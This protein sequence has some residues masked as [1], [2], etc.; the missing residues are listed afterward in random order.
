MTQPDVGDGNC[1]RSVLKSD[2]HGKAPHDQVT[3][4]L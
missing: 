4:I 2:L 3:T 1:V